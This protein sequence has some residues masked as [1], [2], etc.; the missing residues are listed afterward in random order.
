MVGGK[1][2]RKPYSCSRLNVSA[3][4]YGALSQNAI[5]TLNKGAAKGDFFHNTGEGGVSPFH[6]KHGGNLV[7][8]L[9]TAFF[10]CRDIDGNFSDRAFSELANQGAITRRETSSW[11]SASSGKDQR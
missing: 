6:L 7:W 5:E 4:S 11:W 9:G 1:E 3:M 8:Q 10:G 2:C